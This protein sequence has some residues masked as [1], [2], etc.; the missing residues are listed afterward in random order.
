[1]HSCFASA[2]LS[3]AGRSLFAESRAQKTSTN[4]DRLGKHLARF[5]LSGSQITSARR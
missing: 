2:S 5:D 3:A 4:A 1:V